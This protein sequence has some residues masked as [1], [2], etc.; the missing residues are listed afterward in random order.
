M[1]AAVQ[2]GVVK[3]D[4]KMYFKANKRNI[5]LQT[6]LNRTVG[7]GNY[8]ANNR[9]CTTVL[10]SL[11]K[12][13]DAKYNDLL[14]EAPQQTRS[15]RFRTF[16]QRLPESAVIKAPAVGNVPSIDMRVIMGSLVYAKCVF[17]VF[18]L[19]LGQ[20]QLIGVSCNTIVR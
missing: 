5:N 9:S 4:D 17:Y 13:R 12:L 10:E 15:K 20:C 1:S 18:N 8:Y 11:K 16:I 7:E 2:L 3:A 6:I 19:N 14:R